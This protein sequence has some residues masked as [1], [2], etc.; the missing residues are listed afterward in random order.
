MER[1]EI[2]KISFRTQA[3]ENK[4][5]KDIKVTPDETLYIHNFASKWYAGGIWVDLCD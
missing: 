5:I 4:C 2:Q 1:C 3:I